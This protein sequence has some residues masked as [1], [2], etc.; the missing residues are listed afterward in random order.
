MIS[1]EKIEEEVAEK[2]LNAPR[3]TLDSIKASVK[4]IMYQ[5]IEGTT[6]TVCV[7]VL[8]NGYSVIGHSACVSAENFDAE[9]GEKVAHQRAL[10]QCWPLFGFEL[11]S[12]LARGEATPP[13]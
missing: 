9:L 8:E 7:L 3:V 5:R 2:G 12:R 11:A 10:D 1:G 13:A 4:D 6:V